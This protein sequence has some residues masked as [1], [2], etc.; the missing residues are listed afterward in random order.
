[1]LGAGYYIIITLFVPW[2]LGYGE[3]LTLLILANGIVNIPFCLNYLAF[4]YRQVANYNRLVLTLNLSSWQS[5]WLVEVPMLKKQ[6]CLAA[7]NVF[8]LAIG[9]FSIIIF[10][11]SN[12][13]TSITY[14]L[15][16]QI[17]GFT[18]NQGNITALVLLLFIVILRGGV[19]SWLLR[20][21]SP[22]T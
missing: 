1:M 22:A 3:L 14:L 7:V 12:E 17:S 8:I 10:F 2:E 20:G 9:D 13:L 5:L 21:R 15:S 11:T 18:S 16:Q 6:L 4:P 19:N